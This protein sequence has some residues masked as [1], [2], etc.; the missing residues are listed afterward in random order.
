MKKVQC[1]NLVYYTPRLWE[2]LVL[3]F[4]PLEQHTAPGAI[5]WYKR[6]ANRLYICGYIRIYSASSDTYT[7]GSNATIR[8]PNDTHTGFDN[9]GNN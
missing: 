7:T 5:V 6:F 2:R 4:C 8:N 1:Y 9:A 3:W